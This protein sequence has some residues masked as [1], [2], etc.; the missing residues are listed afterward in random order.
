MVT[1]HFWLCDAKHLSHMVVCLMCTVVSL[2][3]LAW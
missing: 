1:L 3:V 2:Q